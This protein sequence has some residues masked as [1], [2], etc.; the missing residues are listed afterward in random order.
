V[1]Q[2]GTLPEE[3]RAEQPGRAEPGSTPKE[4]SE[5]ARAPQ[6]QPRRGAGALPAAERPHP[7]RVT[8]ASAAPRKQT[9][10]SRAR[11]DDSLENSTRCAEGAR[12]HDTAPLRCVAGC[13]SAATSALPEHACDRASG[14]RAPA[15]C[16]PPANH[17][18]APDHSDASFLMQLIRRFDC[19]KW[20]GLSSHTGLH[21]PTRRGASAASRGELHI[22]VELVNSMS[23]IGLTRCERT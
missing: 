20:R 21:P 11:K 9:R 6:A 3:P 14:S 2:R 1:E 16:S 4:L 15:R 8:A 18:S 23:F 7:A 19:T 10:P 13:V 12:C 5:L 17:A 22:S